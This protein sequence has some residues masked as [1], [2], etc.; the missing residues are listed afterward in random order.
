MTIESI[1]TMIFDKEDTKEGTIE[2]KV[3][4][5]PQK[6]D[7]FMMANNYKEEVMVIPYGLAATNNNLLTICGLD[8]KITFKFDKRK[9]VKSV[10]LSTDHQ[11]ND[12]E[13]RINYTRDSSQNEY[14]KRVSD[15]NEMTKIRDEMVKKLCYYSELSDKEKSDLL[16]DF[17]LCCGVIN[18]HCVEEQKILD[19]SIDV[20]YTEQVDTYYIVLPRG[21]EKVIKTLPGQSVPFTISWTIRKNEIFKLSAKTTHTKTIKRAV[22]IVD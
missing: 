7:G 4:R 19:S 5:H 9:E 8:F 18:N 17:E 11:S 20:D 1:A 21:R 16:N 3:L 6:Y 22:E 13:E 14:E 2:I 12:L 15:R 10:T